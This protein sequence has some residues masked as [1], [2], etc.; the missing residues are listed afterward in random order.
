MPN[1]SRRV[2]PAAAA[3][4]VSGSSVGASS[5]SDSHEESIAVVSHSS[6]SRQSRSAAAGPLATGQP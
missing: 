6:T 1:F 3:S 5:R 4:A 2:R